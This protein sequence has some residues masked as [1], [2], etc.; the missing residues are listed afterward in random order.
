MRNIDARKMKVIV[1]LLNQVEGQPIEAALPAIMQANQELQRQGLSFTPQE[2]N[3]IFGVITK[4]LPPMQRTRI[5]MLW[6]MISGSH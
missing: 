6:N 2:K 3:V 4:D 5:E 1:N